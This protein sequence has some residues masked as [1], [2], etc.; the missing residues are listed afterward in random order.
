MTLFKRSSNNYFKQREA[1]VGVN[2][3]WNDYELPFLCCR[4]EDH[5]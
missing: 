2:C 1:V 4:G 3:C 5:V